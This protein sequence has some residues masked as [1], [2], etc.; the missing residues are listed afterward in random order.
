MKRGEV[1]WSDLPQP[2]GSRPVVILTRDS[3]LPTIGNVVVCIVT[4]TVR[5]LRSEVRLGK[6]EG[7]VVSS[8]ANLDNLLTVPK[9]RLQ[10]QMGALTKERIAELD[11]AISYALGMKP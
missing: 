6:R 2:I 9:A 8:V 7:L 4:R 5:G 1:W 11:D 10:R 3:V